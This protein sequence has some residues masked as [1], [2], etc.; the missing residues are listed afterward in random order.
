MIRQVYQYLFPQIGDPKLQLKYNTLI[1]HALLQ[2]LFLFVNAFISSQTTTTGYIDLSIY[3]IVLLFSA[4]AIIMVRKNYYRYASI[5]LLL[6]WSTRIVFL[7]II[8]GSGLVDTLLLLTD[9]IFACLVISWYFGASIMV[10]SLSSL[11]A[12]IYF[13]NNNILNFMA[14]PRGNTYYVYAI[15]S[16]YFLIL[17]IYLGFYSRFLNKAFYN[18]ESENRKRLKSENETLVLNTELADLNTQLEEN[19]SLLEQ[20]NIDLQNALKKAEESEKLKGSFLA[21]ISHEIR[22]PLN[23]ILG[24]ISIIKRKYSEEK[25]VSEKY[26]NIIENSGHKL[27]ELLSDIVEVAKID[28]GIIELQNVK[29]NLQSIIDQLC[30]FYKPAIAEKNINFKVVNEL[31]IEDV[32]ITA[33]RFK[34][35]KILDSLLDNAVKFT[36]KG[37]ISL[38]YKIHKQNIVFTITDTGI[39]IEEHEL[40]NIFNNFQQVEHGFTR[41]FEGLGIGLYL[42]KS[43]VELMKGSMKIESAVNSGTTVKVSIPLSN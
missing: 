1:T 42:A 12:D 39:G 24:F 20:T 21:N 25:K 10:L 11:F 43:F 29:F 22:T 8:R 6:N 4:F 2:I 36:S 14:Y 35:Y 19:L 17:L 38:S 26:F 13:Q 31:G 9:A 32:N 28:T 15:V 7:F 37:K 27:G 41:N 30:S 18:Y 34:I 3:I 23:A 16:Y 40:S 5:Y 33:D